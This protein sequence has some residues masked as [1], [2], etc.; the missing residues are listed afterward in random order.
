LPKEGRLVLAGNHTG[1]LDAQTVK[2]A[3]WRDLWFISGPEAFQIPVWGFFLRFLKVIPIVPDK[4]MEAL[5]VAIERL[6]QDEA[7]VIFP[8]GKFTQ[9]GNIDKFHRG[10]AIIA[11]KAGA[12]IIPF[13]ISGGYETWGGH[14]KFPKL[15]N[16][17]KIRFGEKI[18]IDEKTDTRE[19]TSELQRIVTEMKL[20]LEE[21]KR[22]EE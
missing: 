1:H 16:K 10:V 5:N 21:Q 22:K 18:D 2:M 7:V 4:G 3:T 9:D 14:I 13:A 19:I 15:G 12:P 8:E 17:I 6:E 20:S 11:K